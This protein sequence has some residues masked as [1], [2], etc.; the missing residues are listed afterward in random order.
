MIN[1]S[2]LEKLDK[3][4]LCPNKC[5]VNRNF[6]VGKCK[7][8][9]LP[10]VAK[11]YLHKGEE[12]VLTGKNGSGTVFFSGCT[13][14]CVF[15]QNYTISQNNYGKAISIKRLADIFKELEEQGAT[16]I[17]LVT[18]TPH[19]YFIIDALNIYK[20]NIP[21][22]FNSGGYENVETLKLL[23]GIVDIYLPDFKYYDNALAKQFSGCDNYLQIVI[24]AINEMINQVGS[25]IIE[26]GVMKKGVIVRH[27]ILPTYTSDSINV[28]NAIKDNFQNKVLVSLLGQYTPIKTDNI[29][30]ELN[31]KITKLEYKRVLN[32]MLNIGLDKGFFQDLDSSSEIYIPNFDLQGV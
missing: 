17:N 3:C 4:N 14:S 18:A 15:C 13:L 10:V 28:I 22:V 23:D 32:H 27:L 30:K 21:I 19:I 12:P 16:N 7:V 9:N 2:Y 25:P 20:P 29:Y 6:T 8:G 11:A 24:P 26:N 5:N 1:A 31:K